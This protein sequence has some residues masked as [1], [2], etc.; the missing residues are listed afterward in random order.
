MIYVRAALKACELLRD[1]LKNEAGQRADTGDILH[2]GVDLELALITLDGLSRQGQME[3]S[4]PVEVPGLQA[5]L[6]TGTV[7]AQ[8]DEFIQKVATPGNNVADC[9]ASGVL[10][11]SALERAV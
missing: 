6:L 3:L 4:S 2:A 9:I 5:L 8:V 10:L 11:Q 1:A 7:A